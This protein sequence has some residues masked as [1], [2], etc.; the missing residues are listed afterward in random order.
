MVLGELQHQTISNQSF[1]IEHP[2]ELQLAK[3]G[4]ASGWLEPY[5]KTKL[6]KSGITATYPLVEGERDLD[7][8]AHWYWAYRWE[9]KIQGTKSDNRYVTRAVSWPRHQVEAV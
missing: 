6:L 7:N 2:L 8:P 3:T 4:R 5:T 9:E 1:N